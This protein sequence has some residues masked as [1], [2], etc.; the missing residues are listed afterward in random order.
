MVVSVS[1]HEAS[2]LLSNATIDVV[3]VRDEAEFWAGHLPGSRAVPLEKL[4]EDPSRALPKDG[5]LFVCAKGVRSMTAA[6]LA[7]RLGYANVWS[8][9]GGTT[10][11]AREGLPLVAGVEAA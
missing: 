7:D 11:W 6:K 4:R 1:P 10:E 8:L 5:V 2:E 3:D 9:E